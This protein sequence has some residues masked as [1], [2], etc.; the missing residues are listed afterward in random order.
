MQ[1]YSRQALA[2]MTAASSESSVSSRERR[3][4]GGV[5]ASDS[6]AR[7]FDVVAAAQ[8]LATLLLEG[9]T[10]QDLAAFA[11]RLLPH[12]EEGQLDRAGGL[13]LTPWLRSLQ[14]SA[15]RPRRFDAQ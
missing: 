14:N 9:L 12:L 5:V 11:R 1:A 2:P 13:P 4:S 8:T 7:P 3:G 15:C 10:E 6:A